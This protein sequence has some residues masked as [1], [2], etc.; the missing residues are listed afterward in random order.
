M[1]QAS[2][3][4]HVHLYCGALQEVAVHVQLR[5]HCLLLLHQGG[6]HFLR[7]CTKYRRA[8]GVGFRGEVQYL[9]KSQ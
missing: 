4:S 5:P 6:A 7:S 3:H 9:R 1:K 8:Q 2:D